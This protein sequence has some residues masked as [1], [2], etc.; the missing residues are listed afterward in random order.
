[1]P[2]PPEYK[3]GLDLAI[4]KGWLEM[5]E[6]GTYVSFTDALAPHC[7]PDKQLNTQF[8]GCSGRRDKNFSASRGRRK[9]S[10]NV[11]TYENSPLYLPCCSLGVG[12]PPGF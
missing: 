6:S 11:S 2:T 9:M 12:Q 3:A 4:S 8:S 1:M 10:C 7:S 5:H